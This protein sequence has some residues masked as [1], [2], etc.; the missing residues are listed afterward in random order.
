[1]SLRKRVFSDCAKLLDSKYKTISKMP[2]DPTEDIRRALAW[3]DTVDKESK[4]T[5][6]GDCFYAVKFRDEGTTVYHINKNL[7]QG[8]SDKNEKELVTNRLESLIDACYKCR[9]MMRKLINNN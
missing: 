3:S 1:M 7:F 9:V 8:L 4:G 5:D 2:P 6:P